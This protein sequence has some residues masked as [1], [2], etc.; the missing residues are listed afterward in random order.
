MVLFDFMFVFIALWAL[1]I[2]QLIVLIALWALQMIDSLCLRQFR[3]KT[4]SFAREVF[5]FNVFMSGWQIA[6]FVFAALSRLGLECNVCATA[7]IRK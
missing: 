2:T 1:P 6:G 4:L 3:T 5:I 7:A